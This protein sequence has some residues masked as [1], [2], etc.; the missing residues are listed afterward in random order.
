MYRDKQCVWGFLIHID[1][2]YDAYQ[3]NSLHYVFNETF[4]P[5]KKVCR[6]KLSTTQIHANL[7]CMYM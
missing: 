5:E 1:T 4:V 2:N 7:N 6:F 3:I